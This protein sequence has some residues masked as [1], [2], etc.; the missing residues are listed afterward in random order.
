V[1]AGLSRKFKYESQVLLLQ[2]KKEISL[3]KPAG[4]S[5][6]GG[7]TPSVYRCTREINLSA[8]FEL[9]S[10]CLETEEQALLASWMTGIE[11]TPYSKKKELHVPIKR[12]LAFL[13]LWSKKQVILNVFSSF[14][15]KF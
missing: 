8:A 12:A 3:E 13:V 7:V 1:R 5:R 4:I 9:V 10:S 6:G 11:C 15:S 2:Q 14:V